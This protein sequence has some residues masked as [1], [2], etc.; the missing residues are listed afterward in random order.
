MEPCLQPTLACTDGVVVLMVALVIHEGGGGGVGRG[1]EEGEE[2]EE[3]EAVEEAVV[4]V[5]RY[6]R[7]RAGG[8]ASLSSTS[9]FDSYHVHRV[10]PSRRLVFTPKRVQF[11]V[12]VLLLWCTNADWKNVCVLR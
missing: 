7:G 10:T 4:G 12:D 3:E 2:E 8:G 1:E 11:V 9:P 6:I 5:A